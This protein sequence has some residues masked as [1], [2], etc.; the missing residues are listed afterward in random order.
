MNEQTKT[1]ETP[2]DGYLAVITSFSACPHCGSTYGYYSRVKISGT[3]DYQCDFNG[4]GE[5]TNIADGF[6]YTTISK[7]YRC[8]ECRKIICQIH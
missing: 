1:T 5:N 2:I 8:I 7:T 4:N 3:V 6:N